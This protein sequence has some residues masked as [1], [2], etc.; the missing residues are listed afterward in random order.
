[1]SKYLHD[2]N[3]WKQISVNSEQN[4]AVLSWSFTQLLRHHASNDTSTAHENNTCAFYS[5]Q[6]SCR[7]C[8]IGSFIRPLLHS[9]GFDNTLCMWL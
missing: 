3:A 8:D 1:L 2:T 9:P 7:C 5:R 6:D 4:V